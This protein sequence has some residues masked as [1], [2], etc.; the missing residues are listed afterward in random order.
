MFERGDVSTDRRTQRR[1]HAAISERSERTSRQESDRRG[2]SHG[3]RGFLQRRHAGG[4]LSHDWSRRPDGRRDIH[5]EDVRAAHARADQA[6]RGVRRAERRGFRQ[7]RFRSNHARVDQVSGTL[8]ITGPR[9]S[10]DSSH[11]R[12]RS[13]GILGIVRGRAHAD[14]LRPR[15]ARRKHVAPYADDRR[16]V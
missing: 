8:R 2:G 16:H 11:H 7:A 14:H 9:W 15:R 6:S 10:K 5:E 13:V 12:T 4:Q 1:R 3:R